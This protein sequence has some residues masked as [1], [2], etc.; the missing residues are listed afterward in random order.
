MKTNPLILSRLLL[1]FPALVPFCAYSQDAPRPGADANI[2]KESAE[3]EVLVATGNIFSL[4]VDAISLTPEKSSIPLAF[5]TTDTTPM[6]DELDKP[7]ARDLLRKGIAATVHYTT[8]GDKLLATKVTVTR[9]T[10]TGTTPADAT[11][12]AIKRAELTE[13]KAIKDEAA[14]AK[15]ITAEGGGTLMGF[16]QILT[17]RTPGETAL[18]QYTVNNSTL[19]VDSTGN[20]V[21]PQA[22]RTGVGLSVQFVEDAGRKIATRVMIRSMPAWVREGLRSAESGLRPAVASGGQSGRDR[23]GPADTTYGN[24]ADGFI[25]PPINALP[26]TQLPGSV[27][28]T[29]NGQPADGAATGNQ[30]NQNQPNPGNQVVPNGP[31]N[32]KNQPN[33][34]NP[35]Q[36]ARTTPGK[37]GQPGRSSPTAPSQPSTPPASPGAR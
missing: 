27:P 19:Y 26:S 24:L 9:E 11:G 16:E 8:L 36:P 34:Q 23:T 31:P 1:A 33:A 30:T 25:Y 22:V 4:D 15:A 35:P 3:D 6:V 29:P 5:E 21:P 2:L 7:V 12:A 13:S 18:K 28:T 37:S 20:P 32:Q 14:R 10:L 17:V